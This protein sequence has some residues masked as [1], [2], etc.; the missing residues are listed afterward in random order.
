MR[1]QHLK[2]VGDIWYDQRRRP[3]EFSDVEPRRLI[4]FSLKTRNDRVSSYHL[5][6]ACLAL[7]HC[8]SECGWARCDGHCVRHGQDQKMRL[9]FATYVV[10]DPV[11][12]PVFTSIRIR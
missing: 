5:S 12:M 11:A 9:A 7:P 3:S 6:K 10:R 1:S 4:R 2:Q 8:S